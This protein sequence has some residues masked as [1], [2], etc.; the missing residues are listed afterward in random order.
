MLQMQGQPHSLNFSKAQSTHCTSQKNSGRLQH[1]TLTNGQ[2]LET[3]TKQRLMDTN[4]SYDT[5]GFN[6]HLH[7]ILS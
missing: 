7:N 6:R 5:N 3:Q 2:I 4:R 1:L